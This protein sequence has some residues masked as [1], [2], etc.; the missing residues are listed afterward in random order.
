MGKSI[1]LP[2][3][4]EASSNTPLGNADDLLAQL[5]G[6]EVDRLLAEADSDVAARGKADAA[7]GGAGPAEAAITIAPQRPGEPWRD[8]TPQS[9]A[10]EAPIEAQLDEL[11]SE[12]DRPAP[13]EKPAPAADEASSSVARIQA[14]DDD[15]DD[16]DVKAD[17]VMAAAADDL[18]AGVTLA[19]VAH[20]P[21]EAAIV[22]TTTELATTAAERQ[23]LA[24]PDPADELPGPGEIEALV[25]PAEAD[26][27]PLPV[28]LKPL[29]WLNAPLDVLPQGLRD[30]VG[31]IAILTFV[32]AIA[33]L[34]YV[35]VFRKH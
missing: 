4:L 23:A 7:P 35:F 3:P 14:G 13:P 28:Y 19:P 15:D 6:E 11:F 30:V 24:A 21:I 25:A 12:I 10:Q 26:D 22:A 31:Q 5:A 18:P 34:I 33:V 32:N 9:L 29:A 27:E 20:P 17:A 1:D 8:V 16:D 2:D